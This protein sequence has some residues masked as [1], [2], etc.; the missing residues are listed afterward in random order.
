MF[1]H[2]RDNVFI[3]RFN[4]VLNSHSVKEGAVIWLSQKMH[5]FGSRV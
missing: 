5:V 2:I 3:T 4:K 1:A